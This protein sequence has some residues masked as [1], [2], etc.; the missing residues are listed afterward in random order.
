MPLI[1]ANLSYKKTYISENESLFLKTNKP[2]L[3]KQKFV[4]NSNMFRLRKIIVILL[5]SFVFVV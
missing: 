4:Y 3:C 5:L 1:T 2:S